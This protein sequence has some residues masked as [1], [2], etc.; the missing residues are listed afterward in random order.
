MQEKYRY[1]L[2]FA[3]ALIVFIVGGGA[4]ILRLE[5]RNNELATLVDWYRNE[6]A[7]SAPKPIRASDQWMYDNDPRLVL[8]ISGSPELGA[9]GY[10]LRQYCKDSD[11]LNIAPD[12]Q[13]SRRRI[14]RAD[15][16]LILVDSAGNQKEIGRYWNTDT[17]VFIKEFTLFKREGNQYIAIVMSRGLLKNEFFDVFSTD[18][19]YVANLSKAGD[20]HRIRSFRPSPVFSFSTEG[21]E[22]YSRRLFVDGYFAMTNEEICE[23]SCQ[24]QP[25][26]VLDLVN[27]K[28]VSSNQ[29]NVVDEA[30]IVHN[31]WWEN[32]RY[33]TST[34]T[35]V[36]ELVGRSSTTTVTVKP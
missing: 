17:D 32:L 30:D 8:S 24:G 34:K 21:K 7:N 29:S 20:L 10:E 12:T 13:N 31:T 15:N 6:V 2:P 5:Q 28:L 3:V 36:A 35:F 11:P 33:V 4:V 22:A 18:S 25:L 23:G 27:D 1:A 16:T 26:N 9:N 19:I 14:C